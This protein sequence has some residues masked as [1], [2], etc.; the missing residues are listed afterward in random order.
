MLSFAHWFIL[1]AG[2]IEF[3]KKVIGFIQAGP[4]IA[5]VNGKII[6]IELRNVNVGV[7]E[8]FDKQAFHWV[9][10]LV[11]EHV[12]EPEIKKILK[13]VEKVRKKM[14]NLVDRWRTYYIQY[15]T[16]PKIDNVFEQTSLKQIL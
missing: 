12:C 2:Q 1:Q 4:V 14:R 15:D 5:S 9:Q 6:T 11:H 10:N 7:K 3:C 13:D 16:T 8:E